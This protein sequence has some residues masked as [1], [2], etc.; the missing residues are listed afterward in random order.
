MRYQQYLLIALAGVGSFSRLSCVAAESGASPPP[1]SLY[2][3]YYQEDPVDN[4][5]DPTIGAVYLNLPKAGGA[6]SGNMFFTYVGCQHTNVGT[7]TGNLAG[8]HLQG[9]WTGTVDGTAQ[10]G[11]FIGDRILGQDV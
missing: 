4:P 10:N 1:E 7:I 11:S 8:A 2:V 3:G 9:T 5:E 6:F